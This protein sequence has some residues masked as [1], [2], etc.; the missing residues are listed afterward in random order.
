MTVSAAVLCF[1]IRMVGVHYDL[2]APSPLAPP[3]P[4]PD[5]D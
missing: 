5:D 2:N 1:V 4:E 3:T